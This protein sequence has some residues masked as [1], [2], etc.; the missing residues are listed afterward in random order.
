MAFQPVPDTARFAVVMDD[1]ASDLFVNVFYFRRAGSWGLPELQTGATTLATAWVND[2]L[3]LLMQ[4]TRFIRV[5]A[6]GERAQSPARNRT[7][8]SFRYSPRVWAITFDYNCD[9]SLLLTCNISPATI[10]AGGRVY[11]RARPG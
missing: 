11:A 3:P 10:R 7:T 5:E 6:R 9:R 1:S 2:V 8:I 4:F